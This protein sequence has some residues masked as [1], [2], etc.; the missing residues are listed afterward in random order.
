[1]KFMTAVGA[2]APLPI[3]I[4]DPNEPARDP[5][6]EVNGFYFWLGEEAEDF[7]AGDADVGDVDE[8]EFD[9]GNGSDD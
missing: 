9:L 4:P 5:D 2:K 1:M 6:G 8:P 3:R 7:D